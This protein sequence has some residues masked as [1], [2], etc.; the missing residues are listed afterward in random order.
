MTTRDIALWLLSV[1]LAASGLTQE[2]AAAKTEKGEDGHTGTKQSSRLYTAP[3]LSA[4][5]GLRGTIA[6]PAEKLL[7]VFAIPVGDLA[8]VYRARLDTDGHTFEFAHLPT[9]KYDLLLLFPAAFYEGI[10]LHRAASTLQTNDWQGITTIFNKSEPFFEIKKIHRCEG[11]TGTAGS[12]HCVVQELRARPVTLQDATVH[13]EIQIR[14]IK[15]AHFEDV[16]PSWQLL[17]TRE[18]VRQE[19]LIG[20]EHN[21]LLAHFYCPDQLGGLRVVNTVKDLGTVELPK[22]K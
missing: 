10:S 20:K 18:I 22:T 13:T 16:G 5:G 6:H 4:T 14:T 8:K 2:A 1:C 7:G 21:G 19:V 15:L 3:D 11:T 12:A 17:T 9:A